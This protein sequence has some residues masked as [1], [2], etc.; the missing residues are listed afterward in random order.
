ML[1]VCSLKAVCILILAFEGL[2]VLLTVAVYIL[3]RGYSLL[4]TH[5]S[6]MKIRLQALLQQAE[7]KDGQFASF[8]S[9]VHFL[10]CNHRCR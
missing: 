2:A 4:S 6:E 8:F 10:S 3:Q 1:Q 9:S 7:L 5:N